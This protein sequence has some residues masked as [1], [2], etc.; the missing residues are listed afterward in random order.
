MSDA[1][2][3]IPVKEAASRL[4]ISDDLVY[5]LVHR[6]ELP[7]VVFSTKYM[8]PARAIELLHREALD[9]FD[10][11]S[12]LAGLAAEADASGPPLEASTSPTRPRPVPDG[13]AADR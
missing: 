7:S 9:G 12:L 8:I 3:F 5:D 6:G 10:P 4:G 2:L 13:A 1:P 11:T